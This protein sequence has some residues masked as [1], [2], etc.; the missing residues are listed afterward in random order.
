L[1][2]L[3]KSERPKKAAH[4]R[5]PMRRAYDAIL[6]GR[7]KQ[8][9]LWVQEKRE[10]EPMEID[11]NNL[12]A[13]FPEVGKILAFQAQSAAAKCIKSFARHNREGRTRDL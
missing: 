2:L 5:S 13:V 1:E 6:E 4:S 12:P 9:D 10:S 11:F 3:R 7:E 8:N